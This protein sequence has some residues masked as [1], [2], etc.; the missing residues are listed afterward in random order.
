LAS[1]F[2]S[3]E[4]TLVTRTVGWYGLLA[5]PSPPQEAEL[6][7]KLLL[8]DQRLPGVLAVEVTPTWRLQGLDRRRVEEDVPDTKRYSFGRQVTVAGS[9]H[10][11]G[12]GITV[13][14]ID[15]DGVVVDRLLDVDEQLLTDYITALLSRRVAQ[16]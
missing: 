8:D 10:P 15:G 16:K 5:P 4:V 6:V 9:V 12:G 7:R 3:L 14:V 11:P 13:F 2:P 1:R